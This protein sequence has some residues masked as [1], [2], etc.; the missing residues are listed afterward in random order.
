VVTS[1]LA[2]GTLT[3]IDA[4]TRAKVREVAVSGGPEAHHVT[5]L[6][7]S[8][9]QRIYVAETG[10]NQVAEVELSSGRVLRRLPAGKNG[11][12]LAIAGQ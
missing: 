3:V 7:S 11:D 4:K 9:G 1:N 5:I 6:F 12:G 2:D 10:S 8:D